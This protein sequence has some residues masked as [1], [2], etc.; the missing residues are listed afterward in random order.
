[1]TVENVPAKAGQP[2][3]STLLDELE[4]QF[5]FTIP[6]DIQ[7]DENN[8]DDKKPK[9]PPKPSKEALDREFQLIEKAREVLK[10]KDNN[11]VGIKKVAEA[12]N[13]ADT[14]VWRFVRAY[15]LV[16]SDNPLLFDNRTNP[17]SS[18]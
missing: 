15:R 3:P 2:L 10:S 6:R 12:W 17:C 1:M 11:R 5:G 13:L 8:E 16:F 14:E 7:M 4:W 18:P 9:E